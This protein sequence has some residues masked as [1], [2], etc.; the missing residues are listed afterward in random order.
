M[1]QISAAALLPTRT[2]SAAWRWAAAALS[3]GLAVTILGFRAPLAA[4]LQTWS[5]SPSYEHGYAVVAVVAVLI[6]VARV[7]LAREAPRPSAWGIALAGAAAALAAL[8]A[9]AA[10]QVVE[11]F[12]F[13][14]F[15][16]ALVLAVAGPRVWRILSFPLLYLFLA[17]PFGDAL[18]PWL[19]G[20]AAQAIVAMLE[21][22]GVPAVLDGYLIRLPNA[23]YRVADACSGLRFLLVSLAAGVLAMHLLLR[24]WW[25]RLLLLAVAAILPIAANALRSAILIWLAARGWLDPQSAAMHLTYGLGLTGIVLALLMLLAW[26]LREPQVRSGTGQIGFARPGAPLKMLAG[27]AAVALFA[28]LPITLM[29]HEAVAGPAV[30]PKPRLEGEWRS[31]Q[32]GAEPL[33]RAAAAGAGAHL[34][35][36]WR[37]PSARV[38]LLLLYYARER[39]GAEAAGGEHVPPS[40]SAW[41]EIG[42]RPV[43]L[44]L[45]GQEIEAV[46]LLQRRAGERRVV[47]T[48]YWVGGEFAGSALAAKLLQIRTRLLGRDAPSVR[49]QLFV[50]G[51]DQLGALADFL[52][53]LE[54][55]G[56]LLHRTGMAAP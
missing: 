38:E 36:A 46:A 44:N 18:L 50:T 31:E 27:A 2:A 16:H 29:R 25:R 43:H 8:G 48:F 34:A 40:A 11:Q 10:A 4:A 3:L 45:K 35:A 32:P 30:L 20:I 21:V 52:G 13:V 14:L 53:D 6:W 33:E 55:L 1:T 15:L 23:D 17:V 56:P 41:T 19:R 7:Q 39:Q 9:A 26:L 51:E 28:V 37:S 24:S 12:A 54:P 22:G 49:V 5:R 42:A 47:C